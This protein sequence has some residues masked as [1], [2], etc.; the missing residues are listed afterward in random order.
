MTNKKDN[1]F[2]ALERIFHEP[3]RLAIMSMLCAA[4]DGLTFNEL[5]EQCKLTDGNLSRH[6]KMLEDAKVVR[7]KKTFVEAKPRTTA[8][9]TQKGHERF[10]DYLKTLEGVLKNA[11]DALKNEKNEALALAWHKPIRV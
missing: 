2:E 3:S 8:Y 9:L 10:V 7:I 11:S 1:L 5:K 4:R 6:L